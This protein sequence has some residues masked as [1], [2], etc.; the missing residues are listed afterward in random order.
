MNTETVELTYHFLGKD[1]RS[2]FKT[3][4]RGIA[5]I[6]NIPNM[7]YCRLVAV[8]PDNDLKRVSSD[9]I[10]QE[11][12]KEKGIQSLT[13]RELVNLVDTV[14]SIQALA[15]N[16]LA[17]PLAQ[18]KLTLLSY[19]DTLNTFETYLIE[20]YENPTFKIDDMV[21]DIV[22]NLC[23]DLSRVSL[24]SLT[25][26]Y[27]L[28]N[29]KIRARLNDNVITFTLP[30]A[31]LHFN[32]GSFYLSSFKN[33]EG[34]DIVKFVAIHAH[35]IHL[36][37]YQLYNLTNSLQENNKMPYV[38]TAIRQPG[39]PLAI[40]AM[41]R[42]ESEDGL[43]KPVM[44]NRGTNGAAGFDLYTA[45]KVT[46]PPR[47]SVLVPTGVKMAI[48]TDWFGMICP[49]SSV[50]SKTPLRIGARIIDSD[51]R[52]EIFI[53]LHNDNNTSPWVI[54]QGE[55]I[56]QIVFMPHLSEMIEVSYLD[57]TTRADGGFG[58]T[59]K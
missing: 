13:Y 59:G 17:I 10:T 44:P 45:S 21:L 19:L 5:R 40:K 12:L 1:K 32:N 24:S 31:E 20:N 54:E 28:T 22:H 35:L 53:N 11:Q 56:A 37:F 55:R 57:D 23:V 34:T 41:L 42:P 47:S 15:L 14:F 49:R 33:H 46:I 39:H 2:P 50:A 43:Y 8:G 16:T 51:Y 6:Q 27:M 30:D 26:V 18:T 38:E 25:D 7:V 48:P 9:I 29:P 3:L 58:S 52:G 36:L 4:T